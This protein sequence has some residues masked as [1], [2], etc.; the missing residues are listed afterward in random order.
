MSGSS[1][2]AGSRVTRRA[3]V[4]NGPH[5]QR[6]I[7]LVI[8]TIGMLAMLAVAGLALD[9]GDVYI[10]KTRLQNALDAAA[11]SAAQQLVLNSGD[12]GQATSAARGTFDLN[13]DEGNEELASIAAADV[14]V[15]FSD[16]LVPWVPNSGAN[17]VRVSVNNFTLRSFLISVLGINQKTVVASATA[18]PA[19]AHCP[20]L[21]PLLACGDP[22]DDPGGD[23]VWG[24]SPGDQ[25]VLKTH[26]GECPEA[27]TEDNPD[28]CNGPG[29]FNVLDVGSGASAV[30]AAICGIGVHQCVQP[31]QVINS[32]PGNMVGPVGDAINAMF[33]DYSGGLSAESCPNWDTNITEYISGAAPYF[34]DYSNANPA[35]NQ[36]RVIAVPVGVCTEDEGGKKIVQLLGQKC[37]LI[38]RKATHSG[39]TQFV[40]GE[41]LGDDDACLTASH[42]SPDPS[43]TGGPV[44]I[45]LYKD[46]VMNDG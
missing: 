5:R 37:F 34:D 29:N 12:T 39:N 3:V 24:Y 22:S 6:G 1:N 19:Q 38:T 14:N 41:F 7:S 33:Q 30:R 32:E 36:A 46:Q 45:V 20:T 15:E 9:M 27:P 10:N 16:T 35:P 13:K 44:I 40:Y 18:G 4:V 43:S 21:F 26:A 25:V 31:G 2:R 8:V 11:L 28:P 42:I 17:F 23:S